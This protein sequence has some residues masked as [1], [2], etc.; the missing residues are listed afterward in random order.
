MLS[1]AAHCSNLEDGGRVGRHCDTSICPISVN[2]LRT[3]E[4]VRGAAGH[5]TK[6][7][8]LHDGAFTPSLQFVEGTMK[9]ACTY[10]S[11]GSEA[12]T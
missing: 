4:S 1:Y 7:A 6:A 3:N 5:E 12:H 11:N 10:G 9:I 2:A 8:S